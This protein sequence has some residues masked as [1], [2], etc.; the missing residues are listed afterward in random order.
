[1][2][3]TDMVRGERLKRQE[4]EA[5]YV[6]AYVAQRYPGQSVR[7]H[8]HLGTQPRSADGKFLE[9]AEERLMRV[10]MRWADAIVFLPEE[11]VIIEGKLRSSEYLKALGELELYIELLQHSAEYA[12]MISSRIVGEL[13]VPV[14][15]PT[16]SVLARRKGFRVVIWS[17]P[18]LKAYM[19]NLDPR[20]VRGSRPEESGLLE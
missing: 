20:K 16:V 15:D 19:D 6:S 8:A 13:L 7:I 9:P 10:Y 4:W 5:Q 17:P 12:S 18:W 1:M 2:Y 11:T 3:R 14:E